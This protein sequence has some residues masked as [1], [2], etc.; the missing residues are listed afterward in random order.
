MVE[1]HEADDNSSQTLDVFSHFSLNTMSRVH[2]GETSSRFR[3]DY[4]N[5]F[6]G[7]QK[8]SRERRRCDQATRGSL[9]P[10]GLAWTWVIRWEMWWQATFFSWNTEIFSEFF[11]YLSINC[12]RGGMYEIKRFAVVCGAPEIY[13][14]IFVFCNSR[15]WCIK[16]NFQSWTI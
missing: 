5:S 8:P 3:N 16:F 4:N 12:I 11:C 1:K 2:L 10:F 14:K 15:C 6:G 7:W 9:W 13:H